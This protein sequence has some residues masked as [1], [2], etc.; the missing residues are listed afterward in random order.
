MGLDTKTDSLTDRKSQC[1]FD[2]N[3]DFLELLVY[4]IWII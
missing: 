4:E 1:E 3:F 2:F